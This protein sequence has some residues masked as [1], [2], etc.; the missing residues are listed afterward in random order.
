MGH[1][2]VAYF[3]GEVNLRV[4]NKHVAMLSDFILALTSYP[5]SY[6][7]VM[8]TKCFISNWKLE[9]QMLSNISD[10]IMEFVTQIRTPTA[11]P[12]PSEK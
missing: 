12:V 5:C 6:F 8:K 11:M 2:L 4:S 10:W 9:G 1:T 7:L 3:V